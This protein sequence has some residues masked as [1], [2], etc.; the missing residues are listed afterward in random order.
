MFEGIIRLAC[1]VFGGILIFVTV[2]LCLYLMS[3]QIDSGDTPIVEIFI[4]GVIL[5][6][7]FI[8]FGIQGENAD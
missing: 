3:N 1:L 7:G 5:G 2:L 4:G 6:G 8:V